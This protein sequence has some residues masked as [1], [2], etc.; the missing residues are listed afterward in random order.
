MTQRLFVGFLLFVSFATVAEPYTVNPGD[1]LQVFV[2]NE[3]ELSRETLVRPD[4]MISFP[5]IGDVQAIGST[6]TELAAKV[7]EGLSKFLR[8]APVVTVSALQLNG[9][10]VFVLGKVA[11][12]GEF[13]MTSSTDV[14]QALALAGGLNTFAAEDDIKVLRRN[15]DGSQSAIPFNYASV[16]VGK[17]LDTNIILQSGDVV[18]VP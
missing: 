17:K 10:K 2:W 7:S 5:M 8:D 16:K 1:V 13:L 4:G 15:K 18:V 3:E 9:N 12:P 11:R 14:T 6:P